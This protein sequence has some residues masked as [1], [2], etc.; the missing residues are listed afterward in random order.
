MARPPDFLSYGVPPVTM[1]VLPVAPVSLQ[2]QKLHS[3]RQALVERQPRACFFKN[4]DGTSLAPAGYDVNKWRIAAQAAKAI[5]DSNKY[6]LFTN[7]D[8][9]GTT[10]DPFLSVRDVFLTS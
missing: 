2:K 7:L 1:D 5:I 3:G 4:Q 10:F 9:G 6:K 8:N